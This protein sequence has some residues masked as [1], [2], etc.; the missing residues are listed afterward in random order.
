MSEYRLKNKNGIGTQIQILSNHSSLDELIKQNSVGNIDFFKSS[1]E[2]HHPFYKRTIEHKMYD[3]TVLQ[4]EKM[5]T[6]NSSFIFNI[7]SHGYDFM[8]AM[9]LRIRF[10][11]LPSISMNHF[12]SGNIFNIFEK[13]SMN[14][15]QKSIYNI[16]SDLLLLLTLFRSNKHGLNLLTGNSNTNLL[17]NHSKSLSEKVYYIP[18]QFFTFMDKQLYLPTYYDTYKKSPLQIRIKYRDLTKL[19]MNTDLIPN[20]KPSGEINK[21]EIS[22][23]IDHYKLS[24]QELYNFLNVEYELMYSTFP[25]YEFDFH[26]AKDEYICDLKLNQNVKEIIIICI[27]PDDKESHFQRYLE[28][29]EIRI[30][31]GSTIL[32]DN[33]MAQMFRNKNMIKTKRYVYSYQFCISPHIHQPSGVMNMIHYGDTT[34]K[35]KLKEKQATH[36]KVFVNTL[37]RCVFN[38]HGECT[39]Q[40]V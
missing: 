4:F 33:I 17:K 23:L 19:I 35:L 3:E 24:K 30:L 21:F 2:T 25:L 34:L 28:L 1:Y 31:V 32:N 15:G 14:I 10:P 22:L 11:Y 8:G 26:I 20:V 39:V 9:F 18:I 37:T 13:I 16:D 12:I 27:H 5:V 40:N 29:E 6:N 7:D 36:V 38:T